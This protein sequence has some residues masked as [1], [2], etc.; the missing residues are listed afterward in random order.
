[1][2]R[3]ARA[4][5]ANDQVKYNCLALWRPEVS[6]FTIIIICW[7][8]DSDYTSSRPNQMYCVLSLVASSLHKYLYF[9]LHFEIIK[10]HSAPDACIFFNLF[11]FSLLS[12]SSSSPFSYGYVKGRYKNILLNGKEEN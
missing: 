12:L 4:H 3:R 8:N 2:K 10:N 6:L 7:P 1:M 9:N 11:F 5:T